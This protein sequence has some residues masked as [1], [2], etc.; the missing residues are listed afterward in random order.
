[1]SAPDDANFGNGEP[2]GEASTV[3][4]HTGTNGVVY[5]SYTGGFALND[6][7]CSDSKNIICECKECN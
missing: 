4:T 7:P 6:I 2:N 1:M 3:C 5:T